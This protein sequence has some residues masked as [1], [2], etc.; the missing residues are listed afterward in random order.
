MC[1]LFWIL[2]PAALSD[3]CVGYS[4]MGPSFLRKRKDRNHNGLLPRA[5]ELQITRA[6]RRRSRTETVGFGQ[7]HQSEPN[8]ER[9]SSAQPSE[10]E[11]GERG[12]LLGHSCGTRLTIACA[13]LISLPT[14]GHWTHPDLAGRNTGSET[15]EVWLVMVSFLVPT[16]PG[17]PARERA[18]KAPVPPKKVPADGDRHKDCRLGM[19]SGES[20]VGMSAIPDVVPTPA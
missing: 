18:W 19:G 13:R 12:N 9:C 5:K 6:T 11:D 2:S 8:L 15:L 10:T 4:R 14:P 1:G 7:A 16:L 3:V 20:A 17:A